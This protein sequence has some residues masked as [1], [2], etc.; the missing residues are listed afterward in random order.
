MKV[1]NIESFTYNQPD[2]NTE[3]MF[4]NCNQ[5]MIYCINKDNSPEEVINQLSNFPYLYCSE[6][7]FQKIDNKIIPCRNSCIDSCENDN[8]YKYEYNG[9][10]YLFEDHEDICP[11]NISILP[12]SMEYIYNNFINVGD[13]DKDKTH[14]IYGDYSMVIIRPLGLKSDESS[15]NIDFSECEKVLKE[16]NPSSEYRMLQINIDNNKKYFS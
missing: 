15:V 12:V 1:L 5:S 14:I 6:T 3:E 8:T 2:I 10:C 9:A 13:T 16:N 11:D 7:C 4:N